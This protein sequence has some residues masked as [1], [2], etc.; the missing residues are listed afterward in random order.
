MSAQA[1]LSTS[2]QLFGW[3]VRRASRVFSSPRSRVIVVGSDVRVRLLVTE[4]AA[5]GKEVS[6]IKPVTSATAQSKA[7]LGVSVIHS[8]RVGAVALDRAGAK[9]AS[10]L[11]AATTDDA[12]N[13]E[14]CCEARRRFRVPLVIARTSHLEGPA[15]WA[16]LN[17]TGTVRITWA[18]TVRAVLGETSP[19]ANLSHLASISDQEQIVDL[20][21]E[22]PV[23][24]GRKVTDLPLND[25]EVLALTRRGNAVFDF[26]AVELR[27]NDVVTLV[28]PRTALG[29]IRESFASL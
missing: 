19:N 18:D 15:N 1:T 21:I 26:G 9:A 4:L 3:L 8:S 11:L 28:G 16:R 25:C 23:F 7:P 14:V 22:S 20:E 2:H 17:E 24:V 6:L 5:A 29:I 12:V 13:L 27:M 10:C